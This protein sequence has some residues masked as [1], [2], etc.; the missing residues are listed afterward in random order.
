MIHYALARE[1]DLIGT[2]LLPEGCVLG[3]EWMI[4]L[5]GGDIINI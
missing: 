4:R 5:G 3:G 1:V 2:F